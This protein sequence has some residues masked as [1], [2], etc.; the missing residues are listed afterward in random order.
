MCAPSLQFKE[1]KTGMGCRDSSSQLPSSSW[2]LAQDNNASSARKGSSD[3]LYQTPLFIRC[4]PS[5]M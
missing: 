1:A 2:N 5:M 4:L 3:N